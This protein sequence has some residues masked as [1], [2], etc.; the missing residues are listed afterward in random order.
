MKITITEFEGNFVCGNSQDQIDAI[1]LPASIEA[2]K[3]RVAK[4]IEAMNTCN[5]DEVEFDVRPGEGSPGPVRV[6]FDEDIESDPDA[7]IDNER[8]RE[9]IGF[10]VDAICERVFSQGEF[11]VNAG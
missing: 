4:N 2:Y 11:W 1:N 5:A 3:T 6:E 10:V 9:E 8:Q 7:A